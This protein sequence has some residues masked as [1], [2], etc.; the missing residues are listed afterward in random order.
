[1]RT[2]IAHPGAEGSGRPT[3]A[4]PAAGQPP[5]QPQIAPWRVK[6]HGEAGKVEK[7]KPPL[8]DQSAKSNNTPTSHPLTTSL[9]PR[10]W[11][12]QQSLAQQLLAGF[13]VDLLCPPPARCKSPELRHGP[14][15]VPGHSRRGVFFREGAWVL[16]LLLLRGG[17][18]S[19]SLE[20]E[21]GGAHDHLPLKSSGNAAT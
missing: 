9:A 3:R 20:C 10:P 17:V 11:R 18:K 2:G 8:R 15:T 21:V 13:H 16:A 5:C 6:V 12:A 4:A 7:Q 19:P 14:S 1:M